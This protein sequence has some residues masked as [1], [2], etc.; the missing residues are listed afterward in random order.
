[1]MQAV[2]RLKQP[3][4]PQKA[5]LLA[6]CRYIAYGGARGGG[7]SEAAR[8]KAVLLAL[9]NPGVQILFLR[10]LLTDLRENH[11]MPLLSMLQGVAI[12]RDQLKSFLFPNG[13]RI[14]MG[15]C[16]AERDV[17]KYQGQNYDV[18]FL[19]EATQ[20]TEFQYDQ[21]KLSLRPS[22]L[23]KCR[24]SPR[25]YLTCNPGGVGHMWV[26]RLFISRQYRQKERPEDYTFIPARVYDN[27]FIMQNDPE[28]VRQLENLPE[29]QRK[30]FLLGDWDIFEGQYF[31]EFNR[32]IH[33]LQPFPIPAGWRKYRVFDYGLDM[34][35]C[36]WIAVDESGWAYV[37]KELHEPG[38]IISD[39]AARINDMTNESIYATLAP[40]D[41]WNRRQ[42][43]GKSVAE[44][45]SEHG[46]YLTAAKNDRVAGWM[47]L[48][49][50]LKPCTDMEG[51]QAAKIRFFANCSHIIDDLP[52]LIFDSKNP[53]DCATEPHE[54]THG[55]DAIRY[56]VA[57][58]P[59]PA[60]AKEEEAEDAA[61]YEQQ[62]ESLINYG[63]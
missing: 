35:A 9:K 28:Y 34:L 4:P 6:K 38:L 51:K 24:F 49:E 46:I 52:A 8:M 53:S 22:G 31:T 20:F 40:P 16:D 59:A 36:Y 18:I 61:S 30:A 60:A 41:L 23:V 7:K 32:Q 50:W 12:Y 13:S 48:H 21:I 1:M 62:A 15:Y 43:T 5:F 63:Y 37:Y 44:I 42:E 19:E 17:L 26:K 33:V 25:M 14:V 54:I 45:F 58:R 47:D 29:N 2:V 39:A 57:G 3:Y 10:R 11:L 55:P 27:A 56:F